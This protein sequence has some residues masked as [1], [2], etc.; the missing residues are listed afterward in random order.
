[1]FR[2]VHQTALDR[3][4][5]R[6]LSEIKYVATDSKMTSHERYLQIYKLV[7]ER[8]ETMAGLFD[9]KSRS[10]ALF[11]LAGLREHRL[12]T[13]EEF[14]RFSQELRDEVEEILRIG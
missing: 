2:D 4:C 12:V 9:N 10:K 11:M 14:A 1:V 6:V 8:N 3:Y 13:D 5:K 7:H